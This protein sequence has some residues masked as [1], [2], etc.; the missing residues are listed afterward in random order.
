MKQSLFMAALVAAF[1]MP[2]LPA[3]AASE[4]ECSI[5]LCLPTGF[6]S[7]CG[8]AKSAFK[9]RIKKLKPPLPSLSSCMVSGGVPHS[10]NEL[11]QP[12]ELTAKDGIGAYVPEHTV[13]KSWRRRHSEDSDRCVLWETIPTQVIKDA[14]CRIEKDDGRVRSRSPKGCTRTVRYVDT[15][16]DGSKYGETYYFDNSGEKVVVP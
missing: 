13:C 9:K 8:D 12:S 7:G 11:A 14:P 3:T 6:P 1:L 2:S 4:A 5:W 16:M 15:Y 10:N